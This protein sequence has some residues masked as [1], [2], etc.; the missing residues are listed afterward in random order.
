MNLDLQVVFET[1]AL[2]RRWIKGYRVDEEKGHPYYRNPDKPNALYRLHE[3]GIFIRVNAVKDWEV[4]SWDFG[5]P[6][7]ISIRR[8][9]V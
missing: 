7:T 2:V 4:E 1:Q 3:S 9:G 8:K 5:P 6:K